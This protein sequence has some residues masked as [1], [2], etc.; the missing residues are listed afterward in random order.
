MSFLDSSKAFDTVWRHGLLLKL[1]NL[2]VTN[3][4][5]SLINDCHNNTSSSIVVNQT[6]SRWFNVLQ[7]VRQGGVLS[8]FLYLVFINEL[9]DTLQ[10]SSMCTKLL[11]V[12]SNCPSLADDISLVALTPNSLQDMLNVADRYSK[13][14]RFKFNANKSCILR[15]RSK[16]NRV[17]QAFVWTLGD[18]PVPRLDSCCHLGII[19]NDK[20]SLSD[21]VKSACRKG[22]NSFYALTDI[23]SPYLNPLTLAKLYK[24]VVL[25]SVLYGCELW[26]NLSTADSQRLHVFQH[27]ICKSVQ[28]LPSQTRSDM[29]ET[30][31]NILPISSEID[32]RK[33]LFFGRLCR[34]SYQTLP[35][36]IF[37][38]R[39]FSF[40]VELRKNQ[41]GF[42]PDILR[43]LDHYD[44]VEYLDQ[45]MKNRLFPLN[46]H[47]KK[48]LGQQSTNFS[49]INV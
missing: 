42:I 28:N 27:S 10:Q 20:S 1:Y 5:W 23:G 9:I 44:L 4:L 30:L 31:L 26:N 36:Q 15:F 39:L 3:K 22:R 49:A 46:P 2:G 41:R 38:I 33:L 43:L 29:C 14:W 34:M 11:N 13:K 8:S 16:G 21:R 37:L 7:G 24:S 25:P 35:K 40:L 18:T 32:A 19:I 48:L 17:N 6:Q 47:G 45:W 12:A